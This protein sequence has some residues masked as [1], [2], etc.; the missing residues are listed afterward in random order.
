MGQGVCLGY[1]IDFL[2][3]RIWPVFNVADMAV[4]LGTAF[5]LLQLWRSDQTL[6]GQNTLPEEQSRT[7]PDQGGPVDHPPLPD[8]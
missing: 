3:F 4:T 6:A 2:D 5:I 7:D 1:V 8:P